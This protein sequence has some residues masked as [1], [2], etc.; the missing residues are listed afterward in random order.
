MSLYRNNIKRN[1]NAKYFFDFIS[2]KF[3]KNINER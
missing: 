1:I 3:I 2:S